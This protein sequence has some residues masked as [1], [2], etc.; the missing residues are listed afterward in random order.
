MSGKEERAFGPAYSSS[1]TRCID[2]PAVAEVVALFPKQRG[3]PSKPAFV[4]RR[5]TDGFETVAAAV[6]G[7]ASE[8][9][10]WAAAKLRARSLVDKDIH[11]RPA[12]GRVFQFLL[13]HVNAQKG[14]DW[15][16]IKAIAS[17]VGVDERTVQ[18]AFERLGARGH[19]LRNDEVVDVHY[20]SRV[21]S[22]TLPTLVAAGLDVQRQRRPKNTPEKSSQHAQKMRLGHAPQGT[23]TKEAKPENKYSADAKAP[24]ANL[25]MDF[26]KGTGPR[27]DKKAPLRTRLT[28]WRYQDR[29][30][31]GASDQQLYDRWR[32]AAGNVDRDQLIDEFCRYHRTE[33]T[34][35]AQLELVKY[36]ERTRG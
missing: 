13:E 33:R 14:Y 2:S 35:D 23:Q 18:K 20:A 16:G 32:V 15:H 34:H 10:L 8:R 31:L 7:I 5:C 26:E 28:T 11:L 3:R 25:K 4:E 22:T 1:R 19:I 36:V 6:V 17:D 9:K 30:K 21:W 24:A 27:F 12:D 29:A